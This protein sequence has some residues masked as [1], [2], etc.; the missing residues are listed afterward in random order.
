MNTISKRISLLVVA[1]VVVVMSAGA[2]SVMY[3]TFANGTLTFKYGE[4]P[5]GAYPIY[6]TMQPDWDREFRESVV[7]VVFDQSFANARPKTCDHW[8]HY[9]RNLEEVKDI[10]YLNTSKVT[11]MASMFYG[12]GKL[13]NLDVSHFNT[14]NVTNM[15]WMFYGCSKLTSLDVSGFRTPKVT[16]MKGMFE[17]CINLT[18]LD[19]GRFDVSKVE[20]MNTM[21][22]GCGALSTIYC[23]N[24]WSCESSVDMFKDCTSLGGYQEL[25]SDVT[26]A[27]PKTGYFTR[28]S[29]SYELWIAGTQVTDNNKDNLP[30]SAGTVRYDPSTNVLYLEGATIAATGTNGKYKTA[31]YNEISNL[32]IA[33][34][35]NNTVTSA[36]DAGIISSGSLR[37]YGTKNR[38][39]SV[40]APSALVMS[41]DED[42]LLTVDGGLSLTLNGTAY[43]GVLSL[44]SNTVMRVAGAD[45]EVRV[46]GVRECFRSLKNIVLNDKL[47]PTE[48]A[49]AYISGGKVYAS[50]GSIVKNEWTKIALDNSTTVRRIEITDYTW[51]KDFEPADYEVTSPTNGVKSVSVGYYLGSR[52]IDN[53]EAS[54]GDHYAIVFT[55]ELEDGYEFPADNDYSAFIERDG[56]TVYQDVR[57]NGLANNQKRFAWNSYYVPTPEGGTY[58]RTAKDTITAP[59]I[60]A[61]PVWEIAA[62]AGA[63]AAG[64]LP[65]ANPKEQFQKDSYCPVDDILW[66]EKVPYDVDDLGRKL[67][68]RGDKFQP[69]KTYGVIMKVSPASGQQFHNNTQFSVNGETA[70]YWDQLFYTVE[71]AGA[72]YWLYNSTEARLCYVFPEL[73]CYLGDV[74]KDGAVTMADANAVVNYYLATEKPEDFPLHLANVNNDYDDD[75]KP[76][77]TMADANQIVNS[78]LSGAEPQEYDPTFGHE[79]VD[80]GLSVKW[81]TCNVGADNPEDYGDYFAWGETEPKNTYSW[82]TYKWRNDSYNTLTKYNNNGNYGTVDNKTTLVPADDA[83]A[84]NWGG[85]WRIPTYQEQKALR[86]SCYW[87]WTTNYNGKTVSGYIVYKVK[88]PD[89]MGKKKTS[90]SSI[91]TVA[92]YSLSDTHIFLPAAGYRDG[93]GLY[94]AGS[95]GYYWSASFNESYPTY[96]WYVEFGSDDVSSYGYGR[97]YGCGV[98]PVLP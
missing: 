27:N 64:A 23:N 54:A 89:D 13:A 66:F 95:S 83:A 51:P 71:S 91:T 72:Y 6:Q 61:E 93:T 31:V 11:N 47:A 2:E 1:L 88:N 35:G 24:T 48:P 81:A 58:M 65:E 74:N 77:V 40:S 7:K 78:F 84:A 42:N 70:Q 17:G 57:S 92:S 82:S 45:T 5:T 67:M 56:E 69:G 38:T 25:K 12:C 50:D 80:L 87:E 14:S 15:T 44:N 22:N 55:V 53:Y 97:Y 10:Q 21:F 90:G 75:G 52:I 20:N 18:T 3:A 30:A 63:K 9:M 32:V 4:E 36:N 94:N 96:A 16:S 68:S 41:S 46:R 60:G 73:P 76:A 79:Y 28:K 33:V 43:Y 29:Y 34:S 85:A 26:Y 86:D 59:V 98:R 19:V 37:I 49:G 39:L 62:A 8:F